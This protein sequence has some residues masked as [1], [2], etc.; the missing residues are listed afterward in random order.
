MNTGPAR[1]ITVAHPSYLVFSAFERIVSAP[2]PA[3]SDL[4]LLVAIYW[5]E[6]VAILEPGTFFDPEKIKQSAST[7]SFEQLGQDVTDKMETEGVLTQIM[8]ISRD[9]FG[10]SIG[11]F[12]FLN[13]IQNVSRKVRQKLF[14]LGAHFELLTSTQQASIPHH[15]GIPVNEAVISRFSSHH[16]LLLTDSTTLSLYRMSTTSITL[17]RLLPK[18]STSPR[19]PSAQS[20]SLAPPGS[21]LRHEQSTTMRNSHRQPPESQVY[22]A[23][24]RMCHRVLLPTKLRSL[25]LG[26]L[27]LFPSGEKDCV[28]CQ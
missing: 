4:T 1:V 13:M 24:I 14:Q 16:W 21:N 2:H 6:E 20:S 5:F 15:P 11:E 22:V 7:S 8:T 19:V 18:S 12:D 9:L 10:R 3:K 17:C 25:V 23:P 28:N 27:T 26:P